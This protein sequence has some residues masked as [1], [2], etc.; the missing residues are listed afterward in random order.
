MNRI[1]I[2]V[3]AQKERDA[4]L[5]EVERLNAELATAAFETWPRDRIAERRRAG[6][7]G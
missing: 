6:R 2:A 3:E 4:A 7:D 1:S 5:A